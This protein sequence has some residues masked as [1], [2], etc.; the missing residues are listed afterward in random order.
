VDFLSLGFGILLGLIVGILFARLYWRTGDTVSASLHQELV[1]SHAAAQERVKSVE[2][3]KVQL[4]EKLTKAQHEVVE[5]HRKLSALEARQPQIE[6]TLEQLTTERERLQKTV[7]TQQETIAGLNTKAATLDSEKKLLEQQLTV[8][9]DY[10]QEVKKQTKTEF[11]N[12]ANQIL[13]TKSKSFSEQTEKNLEAI[14]KPLKE[15]IV[16]FEKTVDEKYSTE[17]KERH[18][19]K[20]EIERLIGLNDRMTKET[21]SLTQALKGDNKVMGDWGELVLEKILEASGLREGHEYSQQK[22]HQ[23]DDGERMRP[24][25]IINL[26]EGKHVIVDSKVSLKSYEIHQR[27][28]SAADEQTKTAALDAHL[29]SIYKHIEDLS[30]KH[31]AKLKG[32]NSPEFVL[33]FI[34]IEPAYLLAMHADP[35]LSTKAW[36]KGIA[37]VTATTLLTSLKTVASIWRLENQNKNA[38][39]IAS[40]GAKLYDKFVGFLEDFEKIGKTFENGQSQFATAMGKLRDGP[41]NVFRKMEL[42]RELGAAP[43][44]RI[45]TELLE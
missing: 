12:L 45:K 34:P 21:Q 28:Q 11:E 4:D 35:E 18:A 24:D 16:T 37:L 10:L 32:V 22:S 38:M 14:L 9:R 40:E 13:E 8:Q 17:A 30:D 23:N 39:E 15:R 1:G 25:V 31:Y 6:E 29:K 33:L 2:T 5:L 20:S 43:N 19:L 27:A 36:K 42:L 26:P 3:E 7:E 41:G 44:K